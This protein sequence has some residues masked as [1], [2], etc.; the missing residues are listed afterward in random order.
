MQWRMN[1]DYDDE[2]DGDDNDGADDDGAERPDA[3]LKNKTIK[4]SKQNHYNFKT[5]VRGYV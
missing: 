2:D 3:K 5:D 4:T 1:G